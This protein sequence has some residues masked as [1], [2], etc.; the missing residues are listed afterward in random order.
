MHFCL[1]PA[2]IGLILVFWLS[3]VPGQSL[4][5]QLLKESP[6]KLV[7]QARESGDVVRGAILFHQGNIACA[8][9]HRPNAEQDRIGPDL[10]RLGKDVTSESL[11]ESILMPSKVISKDYQTSIIVRTNG[12]TSTG[13]I[14]GETTDTIKLRDAGDVSRIV[15]IDRSKFDEVVASKKS[16]MPDRLADE[17][18]DKKQFLDLLRYVID[19]KERG[20]TGLSPGSV[21]ASRRQL[22]PEIAGL[23]VIRKHN[24]AACHA[25]SP[26]IR[27]WVKPSAPDLRWSAQN[28]NPEALRLHL[29]DPEV[30]K[31]GST[32]PKIMVA[33]DAASERLAQ[34]QSRHLIAYLQSLNSDTTPAPVDDNSET[35]DAERGQALFHEVGCVACH[36]P[37]DNAFVELPLENS[38]PLPDVSQKYEIAALTEFLK[39]PHQGRPSGRMPNLQ[40]A[41]RE[42]L[43]IAA[44]MLKG[45]ADTKVDRLKTQEAT[46]TVA[47]GQSLFR[48]LNCARCHSGIAEDNLSENPAFTVLA[49]LNTEEG[50]LAQDPPAGVPVY[51]LTETERSQIA[52]AV[53]GGLK[54]PTDGQKIDLTLTHFN[55]T[56]CHSRD[57]LGGVSADRKIHF[58]TT[59]LNLGEQGRIPPTLTGVGAKLKSKWLR[60]VLVN[61]RSI[62]PYMKTRMPKFG[63]ENIGHLIGLLKSQDHLPSTDYA[64]FEDQKKTRE[65]G[66]KLAGNQ[67][68]N[69]VACHTFQY[70]LS[71]TMPAVDLTEMTERLNKDWFY[72]YM[73]AP[74]KFSPNTVM[75]S[76]WP[77]GNAIRPDLKGTP[78]D[79]VEALWQYLL[80][81]RQARAPRGVIREPLEIIVTDEARMLRRSYP[82]IGKRGIGVGYPGNVNLAFDAEQ[83]RLATLW[84]G[85]FIDPSGVWYGQGHG[86]VRPMGQTLTMP[87]GP[88]LDSASEPW[89][90]DDGRPP[91]HQF[92]GYR[93]DQKRRPTFL[94]QFQS[95]AV[96]DKFTEVRTDSKGETQLS[97]TIRFRTSKATDELRFR[98]AGGKTIVS[99]SPS[100]FAIDDLLQVR[101][102]SSQPA[103]VVS[104]ETQDD[105]I[106]PLRLTPGTVFELLVEYRW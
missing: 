63:E 71:D 21:A 85:R 88:D 43:D 53:N 101:L 77:G 38:I 67:G 106:V 66:H 84:K 96:E 62:R 10:S 82:G 27:D 11:V 105:L 20:P 95:V 26:A 4:T 13:L 80:D 41:H 34:T 9:C 35:A 99:K 19:Q 23:A 83:M 28:V 42:A 29:L 3:D 33:T 79:Q 76:F 55:C 18:K 59:N 32:M 8:K 14:V 49:R 5:D 46:G 75:P 98:V 15:S 90:I 100:E 2:A 104:E 16:I 17:L 30:A 74:Q 1:R 94:Y 31:P 60:D 78:E 51:R 12:L 92:Q 81:G 22:Q 65:F 102:V 87:A 37:R 58:Q 47:E 6:E 91:G 7:L 25:A 64:S 89:V 86:R 57:Q 70:K 93:L 39:A 61:G 68:L 69:C 40:L 56:A 73:L 24:C 50:C 36:A 45:A 54:P 52:A 44:Y 97:R 72:Q 103:Q 48:S